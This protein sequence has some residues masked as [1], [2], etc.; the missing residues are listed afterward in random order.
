MYTQSCSNTLV[1]RKPGSRVVQ[2]HESSEACTHYRHR[3]RLIN[4]KLYSAHSAVME[5]DGELTALPLHSLN[6]K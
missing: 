2:E 5:Q 1:H 6:D 4:G 3:Q